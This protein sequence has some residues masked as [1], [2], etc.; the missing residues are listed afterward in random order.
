MLASFVR[1][2]VVF[3][4]FATESKIVFEKLVW[5][6]TKILEI[7]ENQVRYE[8]KYSAWCRF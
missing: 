4:V 3:D 6:Q 7:C 1:I 5:F 2:V 8:D